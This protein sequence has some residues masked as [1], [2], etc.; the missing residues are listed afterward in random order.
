[1]IA[2]RA[3][4]NQGIDVGLATTDVP[5]DQIVEF[6][7]LDQK[8]TCDSNETSSCFHCLPY[9]GILLQYMVAK[10][11]TRQLLSSRLF[12]ILI[13][14]CIISTSVLAGI[15]TYVE[16]SENAVIK[17]CQNSILEIKSCLRYSSSSF[18]FFFHTFG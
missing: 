16:M 11:L 8:L 14:I 9:N 12:H 3:L 2:T 13:L 5:I 10:C 17:V 7:Q 4:V 6:R 18:A 15:K 1:M